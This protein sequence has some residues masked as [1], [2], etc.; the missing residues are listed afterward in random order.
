MI[1][2]STG[3]GCKNPVNDGTREK[4]Q[5]VDRMQQLMIHG[6]G[7]LFIVIGQCA[8]LAGIGM[9]GFGWGGHHLQRTA[10]FKLMR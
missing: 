2:Y 8:H 5:M 9:V 10:V 6:G 1:A 7:G 4:L 3:Q